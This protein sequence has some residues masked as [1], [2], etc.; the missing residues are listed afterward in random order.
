MN[1][2]TDGQYSVALLFPS[3]KTMDFDLTVV[4]NIEVCEA[5]VMNVVNSC[6]S[7]PPPSLT[8]IIFKPLS[9]ITQLLILIIIIQY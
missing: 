3:I 2:I 7:L 4:K 9:G 8:A 6:Y 5:H 1:N